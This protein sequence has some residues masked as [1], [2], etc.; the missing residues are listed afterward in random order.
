MRGAVRSEAGH[1][2]FSSLSLTPRRRSAGSYEDI[3]SS[4]GVDEPGQVTFLT[5]VLEEAQAAAAAGLVSIISVRVGNAPIV[6]DH[7]FECL[8]DFTKGRIGHDW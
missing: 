3:V 8:D 4:V 2:L 1:P 7:D 6:E 5:D